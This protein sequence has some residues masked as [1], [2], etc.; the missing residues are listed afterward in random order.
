MGQHR[1]LRDADVAGKV[2]RKQR[3]GALVGWKMNFENDPM[4]TASEHSLLT[5]MWN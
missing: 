3:P 2:L 1:S 5:G 4:Y